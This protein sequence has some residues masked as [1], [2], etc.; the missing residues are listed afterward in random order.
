M[1][2]VRVIAEQ[3]RHATPPHRGRRIV[4][5]PRGEQVGIRDKH[6]PTV[7]RADLSGTQVNPLDAPLCL[8]HH[9]LIAE[10][11]RAQAQDEDTADEIR[12]D[13]FEG[14]AQRQTRQP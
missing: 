6:H 11:K 7:I 2:E 9:N 14:K 10:F 1:P 12:Q 5:D 8:P 3:H 4:N 13:V